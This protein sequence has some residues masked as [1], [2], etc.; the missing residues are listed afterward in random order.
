MDA[1]KKRKEESYS[2]SAR[3]ET[4]GEELSLPSLILHTSVI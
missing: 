4:D 1:K 3:A 2:L